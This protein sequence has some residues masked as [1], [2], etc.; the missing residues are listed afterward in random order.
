L[1]FECALVFAAIAIEQNDAIASAQSQ[2]S[3]R[4]A[5]GFVR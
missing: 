4:V 1:L 5:R 2:C 3:N